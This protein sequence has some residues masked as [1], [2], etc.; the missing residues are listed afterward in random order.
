MEAVTEFRYLGRILTTTYDDWP[1][2]A[3]NINK[4][5][6]SWGRLD[7][8][9]GREGAEPKVSQTFYIAVTQ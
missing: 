7:R 2:V 8:V 9:L 4:A 5:Q 3:G 6:R 1:E